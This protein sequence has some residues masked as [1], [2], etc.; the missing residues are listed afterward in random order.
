MKKNRLI[1]QFAGMLL[2]VPAMISAQQQTEKNW[3]ESGLVIHEVQVW[4]KRPMKI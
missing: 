3:A 4:G 2:L 1:I